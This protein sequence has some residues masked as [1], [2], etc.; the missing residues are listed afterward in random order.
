MG[1]NL[2][3]PLAKGIASVQVSLRHGQGSHV[4]ID[5]RFL[6]HRMSGRGT[7]ARDL[8]IDDDLTAH[9]RQCA[10]RV[11]Q[12]EDLGYRV[13]VVFDGAVPPAK[14]ASVADLSRQR[15]LARRR[16]RELDSRGVQPEAVNQV[17]AK[18][19]VFDSRMVARIAALLRPRIKGKVLI[20]PG[21]E[22]GAQLV[23]FQDIYRRIPTT[24]IVYVYSE[25]SELIVL[26][27]RSLLWEV[28]EAAAAGSGALS[29]NCIHARAIFQPSPRD[30]ARD[31]DAHAFLRQLHGLP[32]RYDPA[33]RALPLSEAAARAR[34]IVYAAV[35]GNDYAAF[36]NVNPVAAAK[37]ALK[38]IQGSARDAAAPPFGFLVRGIARSL[39]ELSQ[40]E[41][42]PR[43]LRRAEEKLRTCN[44]M[45]RNA[46]VWDPAAGGILRHLSGDA[47]SEDITKDTGRWANEM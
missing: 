11:R 38:P 36:E 3:S 13:T 42:T 21:G 12:F 5:G 1:I 33:L 43:H 27:V 9:V 32:R 45:F 25:D 19:C 8:I 14:M 41:V 7:A 39:V 2:L 30:F 18:A 28:S 20:A 22:A 6:N 35:V 46:V 47:T 4:I 37:I 24:K 10:R 16:A 44:N 15:E 34:L 26:G 29:G 40:E 23:V 17:A 31:T